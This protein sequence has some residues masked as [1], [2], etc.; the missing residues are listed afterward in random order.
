MESPNKE[1]QVVLA[2]QAIQKTPNLSIRAAARIYMVDRSTLGKRLKGITVRHDTMP[3]SRKPTNLEESTNIQY[4]LDLDS[5]FFLPRLCGVEDIANRLLA[6]RDAPPVGVNWAINFVKRYKELCTCFTRRYNYERAL[7]EDL[8]LIKD[9]VQLVYNTVA[10]Y[11]ILDEDFYNFDKTGFIITM[12]L[13]TIVVTN[14]ER[15]R[16][17]TLPQPGNREWVSVI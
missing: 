7:C 9:W 12:I 16:K 2:I 17:P 5:R 4:I 1:S 15:Y 14:L 8:K 6:D 3:N 11:S 10:K 13:T